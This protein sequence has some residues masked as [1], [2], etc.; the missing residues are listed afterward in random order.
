MFFLLER[1]SKRQEISWHKLVWFTGHTFPHSF[2][3][4]LAVQIDSQQDRELHRHG[5]IFIFLSCVFCNE[6]TENSRRPFCSCKLTYDIQASPFLNFR[7]PQLAG[8]QDAEVQCVTQI[9]KEHNIDYVIFM[10]RQTGIFI[11]YGWREM[12]EHLGTHNNLS[13]NQ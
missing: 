1:H 12:L 8:L 5:Q 9:S 6:E 2:I 11:L 10:I 7:F 13:H 4:W 3:A